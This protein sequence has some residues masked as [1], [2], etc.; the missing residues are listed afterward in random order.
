MRPFYS[1]ELVTIYHGDCRDV[2]PTLESGSVDLVLTDPQYNVGFEYE[3][4]ADNASPEDYFSDVRIWLSECS[5]VTCGPM[6]IFTGAVNLQAW[7]SFAKPRWIMAW[8]K[9]N[10]HSRNRIGKP[11]GF[12]QWE[13]ILVF[14][15]AKKCVGSDWIHCPIVGDSSAYQHPCPK[16]VPLFRR[17]IGDFTVSGDSV[18]DPFLGSGTTAVAAK[19]LGRRCIGIEIEERYCEI[20][21]R[22]LSQEVLAL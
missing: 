13:P 20:A 21:A 10:S 8:T 5:R 9:G 19:M 15:R 17:I 7:L 1:D 14:G 22:R 2:L 18:L 4:N 11:D 3:S 12:Q 16:P 6:V